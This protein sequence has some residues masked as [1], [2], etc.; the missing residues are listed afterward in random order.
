M[1]QALQRRDPDSL[2]IFAVPACCR[3]RG[4]WVGKPLL[5]LALFAPR[6]Q[7]RRKRSDSAPA[8]QCV[9]KKAAHV[10][11]RATTFLEQVECRSQSLHTTSRSFAPI[12]RSRCAMVDWLQRARAI[13]PRFSR[14][15][16]GRWPKLNLEVFQFP[17]GTNTHVGT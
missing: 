5:L 15:R 16:E 6:L 14:R 7:R 17:L 2:N 11:W 8:A 3:R 1:P 13:R 10:K 12:G 4:D 9:Q